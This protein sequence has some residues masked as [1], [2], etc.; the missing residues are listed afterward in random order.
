VTHHIPGNNKSTD[1]DIRSSQCRPVLAEGPSS[2]PLQEPDFARPDRCVVRDVGC[3]E[4]IVHLRPPTFSGWHT[5][6]H[7][8]PYSRQQRERRSRDAPSRSDHIS[9]QFGPWKHA[10]VSGDY[11]ILRV[12]PRFSDGTLIDWLG[13]WAYKHLRGR[14]CYRKR[15]KKR[16]LCPAAH[17]PG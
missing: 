4:A 8:A 1:H 15:Q 11:R 7:D 5:L 2:Q 3:P 10:S 9:L 14:P 17:R 12:V 6:R 13:F 16:S